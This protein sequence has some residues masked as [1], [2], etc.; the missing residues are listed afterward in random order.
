MHGGSWRRW[1]G[2]GLP[3]FALGEEKVTCLFLFKHSHSHSRRSCVSGVGKVAG[4]ATPK[5][6]GAQ[7]IWK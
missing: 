5:R 2:E 6:A 3:F 4:S 7:C 1:E